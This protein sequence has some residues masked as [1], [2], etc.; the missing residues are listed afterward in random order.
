MI[1]VNATALRTSGALSILSQFIQSIESNAEYLIFIHP[2]V[3]INVDKKTIK[4][5]KINKTSFFSRIL[6]D[7]YG[8]NVYLK[9]HG[10]VAKLIISLQNT[11]IKTEQPCK[12]IIYLHNVIPFSDYK[13]SFFKKADFKLL[14]YKYLYSFFIFLHTT[15]E[16]HFIVQSKWLKNILQE[17]GICAEK[18]FVAHPEV[19]LP[20]YDSIPLLE[21]TPN[22]YSAFYPATN[23]GY[24]NHIE[25][26]NALIHMKQSGLEYKNIIIYFTIPQNSSSE[27]YRI[28]QKHELLENFYFL[29]SLSFADVLSY[30]K[31]VDLILFP[32][33]LETF[34]LPLVEAATLGKPIVAIDLMYSREALE[35]YNRV[36]YCQFNDSESWS[37]KIQFMLKKTDVQPVFATSNGWRDI[38]KLIKNLMEN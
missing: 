12:Q 2:S 1:I 9:E 26:V 31:S 23:F 19:K 16:T 37:E 21:L 17:R 7:Y 24:K 29:G 11:S 20:C 32:S 4:L 13:W 22:G 6:W 3:N 30:Y 28:I 18:V 36:A 8:L 33:R 34:G 15:K 14:L 35:N 27:L 5:K 10:I 25:I 38:Q